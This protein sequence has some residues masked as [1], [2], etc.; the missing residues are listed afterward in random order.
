MLTSE[1][2][3]YFKTIRIFACKVLLKSCAF[4][5]T[6]LETAVSRKQ[7]TQHMSNN[8]YV[9]CLHLQNCLV[10]PT[11]ISQIL[12]T[13]NANVLHWFALICKWIRLVNTCPW[14]YALA[15]I[16][17]ARLGFE[18]FEKSQDT[19]MLKSNYNIGERCT[20]SYVYRRIIK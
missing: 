2:T 20:G 7:P 16:S 4:L 18:I 14:Q 6:L 15:S 10:L 1:L 19:T 3:N 12:S 13:L 5:K 9:Y 17:G 11:N 8:M